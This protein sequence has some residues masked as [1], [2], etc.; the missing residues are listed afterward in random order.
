MTFISL[1]CLAS[2]LRSQSCKTFNKTAGICCKISPTL[3]PTRSLQGRRAL[4]PQRT[5]KFVSFPTFGQMSR[6]RNHRSELSVF[7]GRRRDFLLS[8]AGCRAYTANRRT[9]DF[10]SRH[11]QFWKLHGKG[12]G[13]CSSHTGPDFPFPSQTTFKA[14]DRQIPFLVVNWMQT[15]W[16]P[17]RQ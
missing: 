10:T 5:Q 13:K 16:A 17:E 6:N 12:E 2:A 1:G 7:A 15:T 4:K 11:H 14:P 8:C 9:S 3:A